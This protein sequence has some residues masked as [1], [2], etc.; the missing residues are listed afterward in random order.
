ME[1]ELL[2]VISRQVEVGVVLCRFCARFLLVSGGVLCVVFDGHNYIA[3][4]H[5][6]QEITCH[7][8]TYTD[9]HACNTI[10]ALKLYTSAAALYEH[11][12]A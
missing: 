7:N 5:E 11:S 8:F 9:V 2:F 10:L 4:H 6:S 3:W 12:I 1:C